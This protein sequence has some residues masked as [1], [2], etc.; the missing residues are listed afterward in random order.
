MAIEDEFL[1]GKRH[2]PLI[3]ATMDRIAKEVNTKL[4]MRGIGRGMVCVQ[5]S[6]NRTILD[7]EKRVYDAVRESDPSKRLSLLDCVQRLMKYLWVDIR[8]LLKQRSLT[9]G[10]IGVLS[11]YANT[12]DE[13]IRRW[14]Q[15]IDTKLSRV[16]A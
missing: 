3:Y 7:I 2:A 10:E 9:L 5:E 8:Y 12:A 16:D 11:E 1:F 4:R 13:Q 15:S 6:F 14:R